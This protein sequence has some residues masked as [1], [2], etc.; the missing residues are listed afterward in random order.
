MYLGTAKKAGLL[1]SSK[2]QNLETPSR[3]RILAAGSSEEEDTDSN[4]P[5]LHNVNRKLKYTQKSKK[6]G[7]EASPIVV[8]RSDDEETPPPNL[9]THKKKGKVLESRKLCFK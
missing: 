4:T 8:A 1:L 6:D 5:I 2:R 7:A 3:G 9:D